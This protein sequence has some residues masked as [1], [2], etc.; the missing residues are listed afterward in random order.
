MTL[1][2]DTLPFGITD[3]ATDQGGDGRYVTVTIRGA[4]FSPE[5]VVKLVQPDLAEF[6]PVTLNVVDSTTILATFD[7]TAAPRGL[8]DVTVLNPDGATAIL[9]YRF[10]IERFIEPDV[11]IGIGGPRVIAACDSGTYGVALQSLTN[12]D[13]PYVHFQFGVAEMGRNNVIYNLPFVQT[14]NNLRGAPDGAR[15]DVPWA[16]LVSD[17]NAAGP[18]SGYNA[19]TGYVFDLAADG[20]AGLTFNVT[21]YAGLQELV[22]R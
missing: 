1:L 7:L 15:A 16:S 4:K 9:P 19:S 13:T 2:A 22:D 12:L 5:A 21:T 17:L 18:L 6:V 11:T 20:Y 8:Y 10:V 3:I 14:F